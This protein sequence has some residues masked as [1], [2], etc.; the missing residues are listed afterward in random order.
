M[1]VEL[2]KPELQAPGYYMFGAYQA[3]QSAPYIY[4]N[5]G[6][7]IRNILFLKKCD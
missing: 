4:D 1:T 3:E 6:V 5:L 7:R 2:G